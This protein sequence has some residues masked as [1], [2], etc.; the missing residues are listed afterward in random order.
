MLC[1]DDDSGNEDGLDMDYSEAE[2]EELKKNAEVS[3]KN[4]FFSRCCLRRCCDYA[5][6][7]C[8]VDWRSSQ[9]FQTHQC[10]QSHW[11]QFFVRYSPFVRLDLFICCCWTVI[12]KGWC[13]MCRTLHQWCLWHEETV[14]AHIQRSGCVP[15]TRV[16][17]SERSWPERI[18]LLLH[19][20]VSHV[21]VWHYS[22][23]WYLSVMLGSDYIRSA[24]RC[25]S[26]IIL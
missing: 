25:K 12:F 23:F 10:G 16:Q 8:S 22:L 17:R 20:Q 11:E 15:H 5:C 2:A 3:L 9:L 26:R 1:S 6:L 14:L 4:L 21:L 13:L 19:A 18:H 7:L 24:L